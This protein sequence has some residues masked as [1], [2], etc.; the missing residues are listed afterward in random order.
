MSG[1]SLDWENFQSGLFSSDLTDV[2]MIG[3]QG[4]LV[5]RK[6]T[7]SE[8]EDNQVSIVLTRDGVRPEQILAWDQTN[9]TM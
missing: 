4:A 5:R 3:G 9:D 6:V 2:V 8:E 7:V 1:N